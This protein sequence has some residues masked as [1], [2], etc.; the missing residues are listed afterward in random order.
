[1]KIFLCTSY[2]LGLEPSKIRTKI[3]SGSCQCSFQPFPRSGR[4]AN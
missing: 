2:A 1:M 4:N 3:L